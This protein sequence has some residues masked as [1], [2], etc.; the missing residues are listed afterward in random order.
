MK[1]HRRFLVLGLALALSVGVSCTTSDS[2]LTDAPVSQSGEQPSQH[3]VLDDLGGV[4]DDLGGVVDDLGGVVDSLLDPVD[5]AGDLVNDAPANP[6]NPVGGAVDGLGKIIDDAPE[7]VGSSGTLGGAVGGLGDAIGNAA[8]GA[9][10]GVLAVTDL[11]TCTEQKY[12]ITQK[13]IGSE[14]GR[15]NVGTHSLVIPKGA[16]RKKVEITAEQVPGSTNSVRF[17]P[18]GLRFVKSAK[19]S[20]S[21]KNCLVVLLPKRIVYTT[22]N[23]KILEVLWSLDLF[24]KK[25]VEANIDHFS[26]YALAY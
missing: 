4:V 1:W 9:I 26:R 5:G 15:I 19:L 10:G 17:S 8:G 11:L 24:K 22:E 20:M 2:T 18:Q 7:W 13:T 21:Y 6:T 3:G 12:A 23:F 25:T 16:L 14:G